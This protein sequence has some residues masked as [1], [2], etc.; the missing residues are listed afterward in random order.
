MA[1]ISI[2]PIKKYDNVNVLLGSNG[3]EKYRKYWK[4]LFALAL[5]YFSQLFSAPTLLKTEPEYACFMPIDY[6]TL[7]VIHMDEQNIT[8][9]NQIRMNPMKNENTKKNKRENV[10]CCWSSFS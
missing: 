1:L 6:R 5:T 3:L 9:L 7:I 8:I 2:I 10:R 4:N